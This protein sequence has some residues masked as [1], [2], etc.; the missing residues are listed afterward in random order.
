MGLPEYRKVTFNK[1]DYC[2]CKIQSN[3]VDKLYVIDYAK[4][5]KVIKYRS[6]YVCSIEYIYLRNY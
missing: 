5:K 4:S 6:W 1:K 3:D 2:V